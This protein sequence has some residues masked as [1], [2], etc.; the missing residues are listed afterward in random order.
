VPEV[1]EV[2]GGELP[3]TGAGAAQ[4]TAALGLWLL[5]TGVLLVLAARRRLLG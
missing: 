3:D 1:P 4:Q 5:A 2:P